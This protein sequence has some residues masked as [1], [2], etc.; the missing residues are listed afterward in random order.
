[1]DIALLFQLT[2]LKNAKK[3]LTGT[4]AYG[5]LMQKIARN[6]ITHNEKWRNRR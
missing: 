4:R 5:M 2:G 1:M 6:Q 3:T